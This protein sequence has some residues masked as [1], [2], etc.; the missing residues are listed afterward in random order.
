MLKRIECDCIE[1][2]EKELTDRGFRNVANSNAH[3][4]TREGLNS[5]PAVTFL[6]NPVSEKGRLLKYKT[7]TVAAAFCPFCGKKYNQE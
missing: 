5:F 7:I 4:V 3:I 6:Y 1:K 2:K